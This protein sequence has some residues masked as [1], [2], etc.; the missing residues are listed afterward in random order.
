MYLFDSFVLPEN[1]EISYQLDDGLNQVNLKNGA[2]EAL[3]RSAKGHFV[4]T[5]IPEEIPDWVIY[6]NRNFR[7]PTGGR[8]WALLKN[9]D[10]RGMDDEIS[11]GIQMMLKEKV[12][13]P[14]Q[15]FRH[16]VSSSDEIVARVSTDNR[17]EIYSTVDWKDI[18]HCFEAVGEQIVLY[19]A[20]NYAIRC[21]YYRN[22]NPPFVL[23]CPL[24]RYLEGLVASQIM[25]FIKLMSHQVI[26]INWTR[27]S[28]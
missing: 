4:G 13:L 1:P 8:E 12:K 20:L 19:L 16:Y 5:P 14:V 6:F 26:V 3:M 24:R 2:G 21:H 25:K 22:D 7:L 18:N 28:I 15:K 27:L 11:F 23:A 17:I 10:L 9:Y